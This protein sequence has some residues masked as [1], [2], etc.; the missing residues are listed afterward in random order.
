MKKLI[1]SIL[2]LG[3]GALFGPVGMGVGAMIGGAT[4]FAA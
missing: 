4:G 3:V 1:V 2:S